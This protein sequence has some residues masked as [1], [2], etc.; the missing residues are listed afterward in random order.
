MVQRTQKKYK[1]YVGYLLVTSLFLVYTVSKS[2]FATVQCLKDGYTVATVNGINTNETQAASNMRELKI[3]LGPFLNNQLI[4]YQYLY[5]KTHGIVQDLLDS[6]NQKYFDQNFLNIEDS[7]FM[8]MRK[9]ASEKVKTQKLLFV[10]HSQGNFYA[11]SL[12]DNLANTPGGVPSQ[13]L[14]VYGVATPATRVAGA[15]L[16]LTSDTDKVIAESVAKAPFTGILK[17]N[18]HI[19]FQKDGSNP[20][21]HSFSKIYLQYEGARI[22]SDITASLNKLQNNDIQKGD[23]VCIAPQKLTVIQ[24]IQGVFLAVSDYTI[25]PALDGTV[26]IASATYKGG[27][28]IVK[29]TVKVAKTIS[30]AVSSLAKFLINKVGNIGSN[31]SASV[32][33]VDNEIIPNSVTEASVST[34]NVETT[35]ALSEYTGEPLVVE[36]IQSEVS[37]TNNYAPDPVSNITSDRN[38]NLIS[39]A[40]SA[41]PSPLVYVGMNAS[42]PS[43]PPSV[44]SPVSSDPDPVLSVSDPAPSSTLP[45]SESD[46]DPEPLSSVSPDPDPTPPAPP[47]PDPTPPAP[48]VPLA[49]TTAPVITLLGNNYLNI[50]LNSTYT[51]SGATA[52]DAVDGDLTSSIISTGAVFNTSVV[53]VHIITYNVVDAAGNHATEIIR[54]VRVDNGAKISRP[55]SVAVSGNYAYLVSED[56]ALEIVDVTDPAH[57][58]HRSSILHGDSGAVIN[59]PKSVFVSGDY[60]Y[61]VSYGNALEIINISNPLLPVHTGILNNGEGG[62]NINHPISVFVSGNYAFIALYGGSA[63]EIVDISNPAHPTHKSS[64]YYESI[65]YPTSVF[66]SGNYAYIVSFGTNSMEIV[67][68]SDPAHPTHKGVIYN[69]T[70]GA[71]ISN[72]QS[73]FVSGNYAYITSRGADIL[74][75]VNISNPA[76]PIHAGKI[77]DG[78]GGVALFAPIFSFISGNYAYVVSYVGS[79]L[80]ILDISDPANLAHSGTIADGMGGAALSYPNSIVVSGNYAYISSSLSNALEIVDISD[81]ANPVHKGKL[82][83][84]GF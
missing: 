14:G 6:A 70:G 71:S 39:P 72:P 79:A 17:P 38:S 67:D 5:N 20:N 52:L 77:A 24:K 33:L 83:N 22:I 41:S 35:E 23:T 29:A 74:E 44:L 18:V 26:Y 31:N 65:I 76:I 73:V 82:E 61:I 16:Y 8:A 32:I 4:D 78:S 50:S 40:L 9:D 57:P 25:G 75:V 55:Q 63:L 19:N 64:F 47:T 58:V 43:S 84:G 80:E 2:A 15:G 59:S 42:G 68:V 81:P 21:G 11:N 13:S 36:I 53:G 3:Q 46:P 34:P 7:D 28:L 66:V 54:T 56:N 62:A 37:I 51:D 10:A 69:G 30:S 48:P 1:K 27:V 60:A 12:Y 45:D 49:D